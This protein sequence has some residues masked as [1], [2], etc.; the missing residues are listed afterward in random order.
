MEQNMI[1]LLRSDEIEC[2]IGTISEK[3]LSLLLYKDARADMKILDEVFGPMGWKREHVLI[4]GNLYCIVS[5]WDEEK[6][7]WISKMDVGT[8]SY[9]EKEKGQ[10]SDSFK[11]ACVSVGI[12]RELYTAPWIW[13]GSSKTNLMQKGEGNNAK[14]YTYDKFS[15]QDI[16]YN[17]NREIMGLTIINQDGKVVY[18]LTEKGSNA[19]QTTAQKSNKR[20][21][22]Q[23]NSK[24][25]GTGTAGNKYAEEIN[26]ELARTGVAL[27]AVLERYGVSSVMEMTEDTYKKAI[28]SLKKTKSKAA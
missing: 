6:K 9:T 14:Y 23:N 7:Q 20:Q 10:A 4:G 24:I 21:A 18:C 8:E 22:A 25:A 5:V 19:Q 15:I 3:G 27:D 26:K 28:N 2:R 16:S 1:R 12:G 17:E 11:R 13:I